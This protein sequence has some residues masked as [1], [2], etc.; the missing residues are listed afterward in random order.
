LCLRGFEHFVGGFVTLILM[1]EILV[2][3][4]LWQSTLLSLLPE[5]FFSK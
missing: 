4:P 1:L 2:K 3:T 5:I